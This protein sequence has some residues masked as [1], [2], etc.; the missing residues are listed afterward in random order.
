VT[1][2]KRKGFG[3]ELLDRTTAFELEGK[4]T[5]THDASGLHCTIV[6]PSNSP[7]VDTPAPGA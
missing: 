3:I 4:T 1:P 7:V 2:P 6:V 5:L